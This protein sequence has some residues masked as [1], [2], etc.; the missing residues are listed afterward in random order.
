MVALCIRSK[1]IWRGIK[2]P[3]HIFC[4]HYAQRGGRSNG[5]AIWGAFFV[6]IYVNA[7]DTSWNRGAALSFKL[8]TH[9]PLRGGFSLDKDKCGIHYI[10]LNA[11]HTVSAWV[12]G[13]ALSFKS[14]I[15]IILF[16]VVIPAV[17]YIAVHSLLLLL[18]LLLLST[19]LLV[20]LYHLNHI[21]TLY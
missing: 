16:V 7:S 21:Y 6:Y 8:S 3:L 14:Y 10:S 12:Y 2:L 19:G 9:Y 4:T 1:N 11:G 15:H 20:L 17:V 5:G 18:S 13:A